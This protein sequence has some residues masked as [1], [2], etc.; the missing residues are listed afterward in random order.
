[1]KDT[2]TVLDGHALVGELGEGVNAYYYGREAVS[3]EVLLI[4]QFE[5]VPPGGNRVVLGVEVVNEDELAKA[6]MLSV[7]SQVANVVLRETEYR[8]GNSLVRVSIPSGSEVSEVHLSSIVD[9]FRRLVTRDWQRDNPL[10]IQRTREIDEIC[11]R[12]TDTSRKRVAAV[13]QGT[14]P[15]TIRVSRDVSVMFEQMYGP[16]EKRVGLAAL[17]G[18]DWKQL[19]DLDGY[20]IEEDEKEVYRWPRFEALYSNL[21][22]DSEVVAYEVGPDSIRVQFSDGAVY[23][24]TNASAGSSNVGH[25]KRLARSGRGLNAFINTNVRKAYARKVR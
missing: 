15:G 12:L 2:I 11:Y 19:A 1:M 14:I 5:T 9:A 10:V 20:V 18:F 23:L 24:Y 25:M 7:L 3:G 8:L 17:P 13:I 22:G 16:F 4:H 6:E 21:G